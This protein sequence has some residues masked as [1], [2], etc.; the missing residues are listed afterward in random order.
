MGGPRVSWA[1]Y[2]LVNLERKKGNLKHR[3]IKTQ[4]AQAVSY[5]N[6]PNSLNQ[7]TL[8]EGREEAQLFN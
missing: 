8:S 7:R 1:H 3:K 2:F 6:P 5:R 4:A